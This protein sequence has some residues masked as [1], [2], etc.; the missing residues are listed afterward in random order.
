M[1]KEFIIQ[2]DVFAFSVPDGQKTLL[3]EGM[4]GII[5]QSLGDN[6]TIIVEGNMYQVKGIDGSPWGTAP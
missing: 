5:S 4:P 1:N 2:A 6:Y 3:K